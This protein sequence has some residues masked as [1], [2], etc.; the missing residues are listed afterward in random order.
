MARS[1]VVR[2]SRPGMNSTNKIWFP[3]KKYGW[4]W[5]FPC[6]WQGWV[7]FAAYFVLL[8]AGFAWIPLPEKAMQFVLFVLCI[9]V[10][11]LGICWAKGEKPR[12]RWGR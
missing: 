3:A 11:L 9:S 10:I 4:G 8:G 6:A 12:W 1:F 5:A 7:V 2:T